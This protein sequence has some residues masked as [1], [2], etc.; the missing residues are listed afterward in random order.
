[1]KKNHGS[2]RAIQLFDVL[3]ANGRQNAGEG[4]IYHADILDVVFNLHAHGRLDAN[5]Q[6]RQMILAFSLRFIHA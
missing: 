4:C 6:K 1:M 3:Q 2:N 5:A